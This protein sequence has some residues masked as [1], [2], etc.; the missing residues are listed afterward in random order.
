MIFPT[1]SAFLYDIISALKRRNEVNVVLKPEIFKTSIYVR[2]VVAFFKF[3]V[4]QN[5]NYNL[6]GLLKSPL[7]GLD[8]DI[9]QIV[10]CSGKKIDKNNTLWQK[11]QRQI[12]TD[13]EKNKKVMSAVDIL[14]KL[15]P[16]FAISQILAEVKNVI[17]KFITETNDECLAKDYRLAL[18]L[19]EFCVKKYSE[20]YE[21]DL[22]G[23]LQAFKN[24]D[25]KDDDLNLSFDDCGKKKN[26]F[27]STIHGV[28]GM[29]FNTVVLLDFAQQKSYHGDGD[30]MMF[31]HDGFFFK[32]S[33][34]DEPSGEQFDD[35]LNEIHLQEETQ[36]LENLR[37]LYVAITRAKR[38][39]IYFYD[40][41][42]NYYLSTIQKIA[43]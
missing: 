39:F 31:L 34:K 20:K 18:R 35:L 13:V 6:A 30:R 41:E 9:L 8:D 14:K 1:K 4:L 7:F 28:K 32:T 27:F 15:P 43:K 3:A 21:F 33:K 23:F 24:D 22:R 38:R 16:M 2:D 40:E 36:E 12:I 17:D 29:E 25:L 19:V 26:V 5:D 37:L 11:M 42:K 10:C